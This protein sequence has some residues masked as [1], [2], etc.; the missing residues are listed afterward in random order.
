MTVLVTGASGFV[1]RAVCAELLRG[2]YAVKG[3][4]RAVGV[5]LLAGVEPV[6]VGD[7]G[8]DTDWDTALRGVDRVV[9]L[10]ARVHVLHDTSADPLAEFRRVNL[11][12][13]SALVE[14]AVTRG[15]HRLVFTSTIGVHGPAAPGSGLTEHDPIHP[16]NAYARSKWEAEC[17]LHERGR[18]LE[19][20]VLRPPLVYGPGNPGNLLRLL[21]VMQRGVP[22]P[23]ASIDNRRSLVY[24]GNLADLVRVC[25]EHPRASGEAFVVAD[26][27]DLSTPELVRRLADALGMKPRLLPCPVGMLRLAGLLTGTRSQVSSLVDSLQVDAH[28]AYQTLGWTPPRDPA[29]ALEETARWFR[30]AGA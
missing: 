27:T 23:L 1:G 28:H 26:G 9:H 21:R 29:R 22:L 16:A 18:R 12:G 15:V 5:P 8:P 30:D 25:L 4:V 17:A 20:V 10:A 3:A 2:G 24:V 19:A 11:A 14:Q 7:I 6:P 13:T